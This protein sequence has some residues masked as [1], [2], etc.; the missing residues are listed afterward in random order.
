MK[1]ARDEHDQGSSAANDAPVHPKRLNVAFHPRYVV[2]T[3]GDERR[4]HQGEDRGRDAEHEV[5][6]DPNVVEV[7]TF[8]G[9]L[10]V[11]RDEQLVDL[12]EDDEHRRPSR[13]WVIDRQIADVEDRETLTSAASGDRDDRYVR[14]NGC[15]DPP[16]SLEREPSGALTG[17]AMGARAERESYLRPPPRA[18][19]ARWAAWVGTAAKR[20]AA[21]ARRE[22]VPE[23]GLF[24]NRERACQ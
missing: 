18:A 4:G 2:A 14:A 17:R 23:A 8:L 12:A 10:V 3:I 22:V 19:L 13:T 15:F 20:C 9:A 1:V 16:L 6:R 5:E 7:V 24:A 11:E 21:G